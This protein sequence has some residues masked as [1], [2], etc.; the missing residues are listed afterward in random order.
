MTFENFDGLFSHDKDILPK[1]NNAFSEKNPSFISL[2]KVIGIL[3][4]RLFTACWE[5][6][7][8]DID[9]LKSYH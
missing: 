9:L 2:L 6:Y 7:L 5:I 8:V 3:N 1:K 4:E